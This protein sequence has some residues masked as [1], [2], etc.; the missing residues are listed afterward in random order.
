MTPAEIRPVTARQRGQLPDAMP[1][2]DPAA[3][4][5]LRKGAY[6]VLPIAA[7]A[8]HSAPEW[9]Y[10]AARRLMREPDDAAIS[11]VLAEIGKLAGA[12]RAWMLEYDGDLLCFRNT[13]EW[14]RN[15]VRSFLEDLQNTPVTM[16]AWLHRFLAAGEAVMINRVDELPRPARPLQVEML[17][18]G[19]KSVL[20]VPV[21][22]DGR[23]RACI[24]LDATNAIRRW[25]A[26]DIKALFQCAELIGLARYGQQRETASPD[27]SAAA[28]RPL[29]YLR[30]Q[31]SAVGIEPHAILGVRSARD[32]AEVWLH[33][34]TK[35][36]DLR[37]LA[38][39]AG[40]LPQA[41][42]LRIHRTAIVNLRHVQGLDRS[43]G[44]RWR[45]AFRQ[46]D[47][48]WPVSRP[49]RQELRQRLGI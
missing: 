33:N 37:P 14:S 7:C 47:E 46:L 42:F 38:L 2:A 39:W 3:E 12:D 31:G 22:H 45:V 48:T 32:Y 27:G 21:F 6:E 35:V 19:D 24:G 13:H 15:G 23:L 17:R 16:I 5:H 36:L 20:S 34:G 10:L 29:I 30:K 44:D 1:P 25:P 11:A 43:A 26:S 28:F 4:A 49:H 41:S 40:L 8:A 9:A 18:Q